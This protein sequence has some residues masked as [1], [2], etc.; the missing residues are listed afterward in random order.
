L[1]LL[2]AGDERLEVALKG[3]I[4]FWNQLDR[5]RIR[6]QARGQRSVVKH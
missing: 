6:V 4:E 2:M 5:L 3:E 1:G